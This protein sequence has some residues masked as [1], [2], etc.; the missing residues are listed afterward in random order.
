MMFGAGKII[1]A[2]PLFSHTKSILFVKFF[3]T[4][5]RED[6]YFFHI[7]EPLK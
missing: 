3:T 5:F 7:L 6:T 4:E 2:W 1:R